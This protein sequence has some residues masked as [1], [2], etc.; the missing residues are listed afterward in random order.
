MMDFQEVLLAAMDILAQ[1]I[2]MAIIGAL[3]GIMIFSAVL[4]GLKVLMR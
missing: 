1:P 2:V 3:G 4:V